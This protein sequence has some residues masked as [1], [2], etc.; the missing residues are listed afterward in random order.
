VEVLE[1]ASLLPRSL[2]GQFTTSSVEAS[3]AVVL[4]LCVEGKFM[5]ISIACSCGKK[6]RVKA[7]RLV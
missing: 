2:T 3:S 5:P 4:P 7:G 6:Y 1:V